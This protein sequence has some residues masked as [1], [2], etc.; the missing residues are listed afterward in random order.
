MFA[1]PVTIQVDPAAALAYRSV[2]EDERRKLDLLRRL[3][4]REMTRPGASLEDVMDEISRSAHE[5]GLTPEI[6]QAI[7]NER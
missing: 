4:L 1:E 6:L 3:R 7:L 5:R 2:S